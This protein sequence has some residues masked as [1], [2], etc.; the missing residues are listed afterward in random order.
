M[1]STPAIINDWLVKLNDKTLHFEH[2]MN[3]CNNLESVVEEINKELDKFYRNE[4]K[5]KRK[6]GTCSINN[7][8][9]LGY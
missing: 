4:K 3:Y 9:P 7:R 1:K 6:Y 8:H 2:R 5:A